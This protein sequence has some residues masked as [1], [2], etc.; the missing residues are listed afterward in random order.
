[1]RVLILIMIKHLMQKIQL[2]LPKD[3]ETIKLSALSLFDGAF[4]S[5]RKQKKG[6]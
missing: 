1:M 4:E 5:S 2:N 6:S 3:G